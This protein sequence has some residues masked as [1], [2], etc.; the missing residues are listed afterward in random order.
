MVQCRQDAVLTRFLCLELFIST[1]FVAEMT[2]PLDPEQFEEADDIPL[3]QH[4]ASSSGDDSADVATLSL[5]PPPVSLWFIVLCGATNLGA[6]TAWSLQFA[7]VTPFFEE[8]LKSGPVVSHAVW[9]LGPISGLIVAPLIGI[10]SDRC[11]SKWGRRRP[12]IV[13]GTALGV[14]G[15]LMYSHVLLLA[16]LLEPWVGHFQQKLPLIIAVIAF[17]II[18]FSLNVFHWP[19]RALLGDVVPSEQQHAIQGALIIGSSLSDLVVNA[20]LHQLDEPVAYVRLLY[21]LTMTLFTLSTLLLLWLTRGTDTSL[22]ATKPR[23]LAVGQ[24]DSQ[25]HQTSNP[26]LYIL[27]MPSWLWRIGLT[28]FLGWL[29]LF[30]VRPNATTWLGSS[31]LGGDPQAPA[32]SPLLLKYEQGVNLY[33]MASVVR[34]LLQITVGA[35]YSHLIKV[36]FKPSH[37]VGVAYLISSVLLVSFARTN[38][39]LLGQ[40]VIV[41][42]ALPMAFTF[43]TT[44]AVPVTRSSDADRCINLGIVNVFAVCAQIADTMYTGF[45]SKTFGESAVMLVGAAWGFSAC[46]AAFIYDW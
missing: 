33:G 6:G 23:V 17:A 8:V 13:A 1:T 2:N 32:G 10:W 38:N 46:V 41:S 3:A 22:L 7:L 26:V 18:V 44:N 21:M 24:S 30:C 36:G 35:V 15:M 29:M 11:L 40:L 19:S 4:H 20:V 37:Q 16:S 12:F 9:V 43:A 42:L 5:K 28:T 14:V 34:T 27:T 31:V 25:I 39:P 45:I